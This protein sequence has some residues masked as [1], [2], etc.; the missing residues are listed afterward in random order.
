MFICVCLRHVVHSSVSLEAFTEHTP[1]T[2]K[3]VPLLNVTRVEFFPPE[4]RQR[5]IP[6]ATPGLGPAPRPPLPGA[7]PLRTAPGGPPETILGASAS[8]PTL[9]SGMVTP[10]QARRSMSPYSPVMGTGPIRSSST[11]HLSCDKDFIIRA[12][13]H[14][15]PLSLCLLS[16]SL[17]D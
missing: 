11:L 2:D 15:Y 16:L 1:L 8:S 5:H 9:T 12:F 13:K 14:T 3:T 17:F 7:T 4:L 10:P 6:V